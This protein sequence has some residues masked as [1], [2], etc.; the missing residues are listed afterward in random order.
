[1]TKQYIYRIR[2]SQ[3]S[4]NYH[5]LI[6]VF[7]RIENM[8]KYIAIKNGKLSLHC[9]KWGLNYIK[10]TGNKSD[11]DIVQYVAQYIENM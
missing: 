2:C 9:R 10:Q 3:K 1:M 7:Q 6:G 8:E 4:L 5:E 11:T